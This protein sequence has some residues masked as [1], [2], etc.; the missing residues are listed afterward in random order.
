MC[1]SQLFANF[2]FVIGDFATD[3]QGGDMGWYVRGRVVTHQLG[4]YLWANALTGNGEVA[5][6]G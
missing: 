2:S 4:T 3:G 6:R 5:H 1:A